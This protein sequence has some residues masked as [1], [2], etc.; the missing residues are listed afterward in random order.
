M[1]RRKAEKSM[2]EDGFNGLAPYNAAAYWSHGGP[3][4][5]DDFYRLPEDIQ[6]QV[7]QRAMERQFHSEEELRD[8]V[9]LLLLK[10]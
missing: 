10:A 6:E 5:E 9:R 7:N 4:R 8:Y 3:Y 2:M 1:P